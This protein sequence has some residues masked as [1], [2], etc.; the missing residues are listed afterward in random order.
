[1]MRRSLYFSVALLV[2]SP[3]SAAELIVTCSD[4]FQSISR[5]LEVAFGDKSLVWADVMVL[6]GC[7]SGKPEQITTKSRLEDAARLA[8][9][10][11]RE[12]VID[13]DENSTKPV[14]VR[15]RMFPENQQTSPEE[16]CCRSEYTGHTETEAGE[17]RL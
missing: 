9:T 12:T 2:A 13:Y 8:R 15:L 1:M 3:A 7:D 17:D 5:P 10:L 11:C 4:V 6:A 16:Y 14:P